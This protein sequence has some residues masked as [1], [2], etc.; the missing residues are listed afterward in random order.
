MLRWVPSMRTK[1]A[2]TGAS[3]ISSTPPLLLSWPYT[4]VHWSLPFETWISYFTAWAFSQRSTTRSKVVGAP[5]STAIHDRS[6][7]LEDQRVSPAP[8]TANGAATLSPSLPLLVAILPCAR[9]AVFGETGCC[10]CCGGCGDTTVSLAA[11]LVTLPATLLTCTLML[12]P[13]SLAEV[14]AMVKVGTVV[15]PICT[16]PFSQL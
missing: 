14:V 15:V 3:E 7:N 6:S 9:F 16:S 12:A 5:R 8:S 13:S 10:G 1:R 11:G 4:L 2:V